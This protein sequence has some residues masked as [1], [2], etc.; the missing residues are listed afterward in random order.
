MKNTLKI[1]TRSSP[2][3]LWQADYAQTE[4]KKHGI[5]SEI[6]P[7]ESEGD[8]DLTTPLYKMGIQG[9]FTRSL[10][11]AL[12][13]KRIDLAVHSMKDVP[14]TLAE[15]LVIA[16]V[17]P[18]GKYGDVLLVKDPSLFSLNNASL[19]SLTIA[20]SSIRRRAQWLHQ[21]PHHTLVDLRGNIHTRLKKLHDNAW[22]GAIFAAAALD[23]LEFDIT[24]VIE[25]DWMLSAPSQ[26]AVCVVC[27][28]SD[29]KILARC[30]GINHEPTAICT[31]IEREFLKEMQGGCSTPIGALATITSNSIH[32]K[33]RICSTDGTY[34]KDIARIAPVS[35]Y[36]AIGREVAME[37]LNSDA[38][39]IIDQFI[40]DRLND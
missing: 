9:I 21:Y 8:L 29:T 4:L 23:R 38:K 11:A 10:D 3:A 40:K 39:E 35:V 32:F 27:R 15:G 37:F 5:S 7:I 17:L 12:L 34:T 22:D 30:Q 16:A 26:G 28:A 6:T 36:K 31:H 14:T 24:N 18:R 13:N 19:Q 20:T 33:G 1:G 25:L 2:L